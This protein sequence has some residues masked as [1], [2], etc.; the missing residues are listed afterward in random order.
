MS[1]FRNFPGH[2][3]LA[4]V[5]PHRTFFLSLVE[6]LIVSGYASN[7]FKIE[8][9]RRVLFVEFNSLHVT[10]RLLLHLYVKYL[11]CLDFSNRCPHVFGPSICNPHIFADNA[12]LLFLEECLYVLLYD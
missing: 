1:L 4:T 6:Y 7:I 3:D 5:N 11:M 10:L 9:D 8:L 2:I 12:S